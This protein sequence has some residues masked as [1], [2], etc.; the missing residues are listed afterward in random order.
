MA[1]IRALQQDYLFEA[2]LK[3][4]ATAYSAQ[5]TWLK[6]LYLAAT[7]NRAGGEVTAQSF[8]GTSHS[9]QYRG[10]TP[11]EHRQALRLAIEYVEEVSGATRSI[12][13]GGIKLNFSYRT[14]ST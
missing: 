9:M 8:A 7:E 1:D 12:P 14:T 5:L 3:F 13:A 2:R 11:E 4:G 6:D 10:A